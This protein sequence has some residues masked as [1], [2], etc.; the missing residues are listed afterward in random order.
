MKKFCSW[1]GLCPNW[2]KSGGRVKSS[3][4]RRGVNRAA[5]ALRVAARSLHHS[6]G[7]LGGFLRRMKGRLGVQAA[8]T[9]T[10]H[11]LARIVYLALKH[12]MT[13]VRQSQEEYEAQMKEKQ[14]KALQRK[15]RQ[16]GL[17]VVEKPSVSGATATAAPV[18]G[19]QK[20]ARGR[21]ERP[22]SNEG[23]QPV[24]RGSG[25]GRGG[26][27]PRRTRESAHLGALGKLSEEVPCNRSTQDLTAGTLGV[28]PHRAKVFF[29]SFRY[30][31]GSW[32]CARRVVAKVEWHAGELFR[33]RLALDNVRPAGLPGGRLE[34]RFH[35]L[36][37]PADQVLAVFLIPQ[38]VGLLGGRYVSEVG[39]RVGRGGPAA[40]R[41]LPLVQRH[42]A[43][44]AAKAALAVVVEL[45]QLS[46]QD[47]E[48]V[49]DQV[50]GILLLQA[51]A[52]RPVVDKRGIELHE[53]RPG[54]GLAG[55]AQAL[56]QTRR[57]RVHGG[58]SGGAGVSA[59]SA[60][61][62]AVASQIG[63]EIP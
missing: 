59:L 20:W 54:A 25:S 5:Q 29:H 48:N 17:E 50:G 19:Q 33:R 39:V 28:G 62:G 41:F 30:Q 36:Q 40:P 45:R 21:R 34:L 26:C 9:A 42:H 57:G 58:P 24:R 22:G 55:R 12:G 38:G 32:E 18:Q 14:L 11:K 37:G 52:P 16:L 13:Y 2:Q 43:Q 53:P 7:A 31:A 44:P 63:D 61:G 23:E 46:Q 3:R 1:L 56:Q 35:H 51:G 10:A 49:L 4:T 47:G 8:L 15:A 6:Q 60:A 27:A